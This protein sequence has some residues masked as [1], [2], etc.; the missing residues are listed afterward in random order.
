[1]ADE[2]PENLRL[3]N[4]RLASENEE[5]RLR[6]DEAEQALEAIR[7]GEADSLVIDGPN[8]PRIF[9][10]EGADHAYRIFV[11][12]M[13]EGAATLGE[14]G[15]VLYCN[16]RFAGMLDAPLE[17]VMGDSIRRF[18]PEH[19]RAA[20]T[21]LV[22]EAEAGESRGEL[23]LRSQ[24]DELVPAYL[25]VSLIEDENRRRFCLIAADLRHQKRS[26]EVLA[27]ERFARSVLEQAADAIV[28]CDDAGRIVR[29]SDSAR[30]VCP[31]EPLRSRF[32]DAFPLAFEDTAERASVAARA[33]S[34]EVLRAVP[35]S[36]RCPD[37]STADLLV[38]AKGLYGSHGRLI[39]FIVTLVDVTDR[40]RAAR[41]LA[42][43]N[44]ALAEADR[45]KTHFLAVLSHEL[46][47][48]LAAINNGL[49]LLERAAPG[50]DPARRALE[51]IERQAAQLARLVDDLLDVTRI[52]RNKIQLQRR[53]LELN[54]LVRRTLE[55]HR[56]EFEKHQVVL[57]L[58]PSPIPLHVNGDANRL[59]QAFGNLLRNAAKF[60]SRGGLTRVGVEADEDARRAVVRVA[61]TGVGISQPML[62][63]LFE[64]F[65]QADETLDRSEGGLG[66]GLSL[67]KGL[68][69]A[70]GGEVSAHSEG[71]GQGAE[72]VV[73]LPLE[74]APVAQPATLRPGP[75]ERA[76]RRVLIIEDNVDAADT[77]SEVLAL[78]DHEV[79]VAYNGPDGL[80]K[81]RTFHPDIVLC[82]I[83]LPGMDGYAVARAFRADEALKDTRL[84]ALTGYALPDDLQRATDAGFERHIAKPPTLAKLERLLADAR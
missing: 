52:T 70:H 17:H 23:E 16:A 75:T 3:E 27:A 51:V 77:L 65:A 63:R 41:E 73:R 36:L 38:S 57:E 83:G 24:R 78:S 33:M 34:G 45:R 62:A 49:N 30:E 29:L 44:A 61:D 35:A 59:A 32:E 67:V 48:P 11:E 13:N 4:E 69:E 19:S 10:L 22:R 84:V 64:P 12:A 5:L 21:A 68:V 82:D 25:S 81:A 20:F 1:M 6:L 47:N 39:G 53:P 56:S 79:A 8:G 37:G 42:L 43:A 60:T 31:E 76:Q 50:G 7:T 58:A 2:S 72:L 9:S 15:T 40:L 71:L 74:E 55:D 80:E 26:E 18:V 46:R 66:L 54:E 28:V 14:D